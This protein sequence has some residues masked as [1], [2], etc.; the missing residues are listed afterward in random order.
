MFLGGVSRT[1][2]MLALNPNFSGYLPPRNRMV[3]QDHWPHPCESRDHSTVLDLTL[4]SIIN[5]A[6][7]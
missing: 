2:R 1:N 5:P 4:V 7:F 6:E 3:R